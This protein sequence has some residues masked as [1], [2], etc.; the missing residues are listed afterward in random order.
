MSLTKAQ[1]LFY[2]FAA[3]MGVSLSSILV[4]YD[5]SSV[6]RAFFVTAGAF[7]GLSLYGYTTKRDG[8][9]RWVLSWLLAC[10]G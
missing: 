8:L 4:V 9:A 1:T 6:A 10:S 5:G 3:L 2:V 7:A